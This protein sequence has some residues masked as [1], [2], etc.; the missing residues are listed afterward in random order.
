MPLIVKPPQ[1]WPASAAW[2]TDTNATDLQRR[3]VRRALHDDGILETPLGSNR[4]P[5][6]DSLCEWAGSPVA[7][8]WC[9][10]WAG[11][12][13]ADAGAKVPLGFPSCDAWLP[14][15]TALESVP[16]EL[17]VG[18][19]VLYGRGTDA[20]HIG[21]IAR[22]HPQLVLTIEGNRG[23]AGSGTNNGVAVDLAPLTRKDV[24]GLVLPEAAP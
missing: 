1:P 3:I 21:I 8:Y 20:Q 9:A 10:I 11:R 22:V 16:Q 17:R 19:C 14:F 23:Y 12:V 6:L 2:L 24:L 13:W 15:A 4:S 5:Y 7:S 18:A